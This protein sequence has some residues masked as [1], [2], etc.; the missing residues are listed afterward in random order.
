MQAR[1][2]DLA[3]I[4]INPDE[5][6]SVCLITEHFQAEYPVKSFF[7]YIFWLRNSYGTRTLEAYASI[8]SFTRVTPRIY[9]NGELLSL[10]IDSVQPV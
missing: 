7:K 5:D 3:I 10:T 9:W 1:V 2:G 6:K 4:R 8:D